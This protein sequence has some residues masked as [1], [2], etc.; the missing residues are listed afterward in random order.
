MRLKDILFSVIVIALALVLYISSNALP[1]QRGAI[2]GPA[3]FPKL[4]AVIIIISSVTNIIKQ[5]VQYY[6]QKEVPQEGATNGSLPEKRPDVKKLIKEDFHSLVSGFKSNASL[7]IVSV[8]LVLIGYLLLIN[9]LGYLIATLCFSFTLMRFHG[10]KNKLWLLG[11]SAGITAF[12]IIV[13]QFWLNVPLP[14][15]VIISAIL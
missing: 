8:I 11:A 1:P 5:V 14:E 15:G 3:F 2:V 4:L 10:M 13:F 9:Y 12:T 6:K 7:R